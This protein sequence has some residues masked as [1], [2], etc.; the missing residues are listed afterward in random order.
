MSKYGIEN[1]PGLF[2]ARMEV[3]TTLNYQGMLIRDGLI[4]IETLFNYI[5]DAAILFWDKS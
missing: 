2:E 3:Q 4:D 5:G 1:N